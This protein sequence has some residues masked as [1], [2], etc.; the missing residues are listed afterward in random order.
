MIWIHGG[1]FVNGHKNEFGR[2]TGLFNA[3]NYKDGEEEPHSDGMIY[4]STI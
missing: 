1:G 4:V 3:S 2:P